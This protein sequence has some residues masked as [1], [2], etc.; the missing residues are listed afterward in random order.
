MAVPPTRSRCGTRQ[1]LSPSPRGRDS[2]PREGGPGAVMQLQDG[3]GCGTDTSLARSLTINFVC[4]Q[5][6]A[7]GIATVTF[8]NETSL[9][10]YAATI[11]TL[12]VCPPHTVSTCGT[13][14]L[15]LTSIT[16]TDLVYVDTTRNYT[17]YYRPCGVVTS[18]QC[19]NNSYADVDASMLCQAAGTAG[20]LTSNA[21]D[22]AWWNPTLAN[23][24]RRQN[25]NWW[26]LTISDGQTCDAAAGVS[27]QL[28][29]NF[30]CSASATTPV[31]T[32]VN[33]TTTCYYVATVMT[34]LACNTTGIITT[35][36]DCGGDYDLD[37]LSQQD[38]V[39]TP[40]NSGFSYALRPCC[41]VA[42]A[43]CQAHNNT[44]SSMM[45]QTQQGS[46][47]TFDLAI[48]DPT[49]VSYTPT[50]QGISMYLSDGDFCAATGV[51]RSLT[52]NINCQPGPLG[53]QAKLL[54]VVEANTCQYVATVTTNQVCRVGR[55]NGF[56]GS[57]NYDFSLAGGVDYQWTSADGQYT[58]YFQPCGSVS[59]PQCNSSTAAQGSMM[60]Q[61]V[62]GTGTAYDIA[63]YDSNLV[64][65]YK[66]ASGGMQLFVQDGTS[67]GGSGYLRALTVNF[68]CGA[69]P[70][71]NNVTETTT[72]NY[73]AFV[74]TP[75][76]CSPVGAG[77]STGVMLSY[78]SSTGA[79]SY[80]TPSTCGG[81]YN[82]APLTTQDLSYTSQGY[83]WYL[84]PCG[85]VSNSNC[86]AAA[87]AV[88]TA[89]W[90]LCQDSQSGSG[91]YDASLYTPYQASYFPIRNG[92]IMQ[93]ADGAVCG[94]L[95]SRVTRVLFMCNASATSAYIYN[96]TESPECTYNVYV[97][98]NLTCPVAATTCG[99]A[100]Y[101]LSALTRRGDLQLVNASSGYN[102]YFSPCSI[103][104][105]SACQA[106]PDTADAMMCQVAA[107]SNSTY[108]VAVYAPQLTQ[109]TALSNG[110]QMQIQDG[111]SSDGYDFER[112]LTVNFVCGQSGG[113]QFVSMYEATLCSY[114]AQ[115]N[116]GLACSALQTS[117]SS[118]TLSGGAIAGI[119][120]G[121][122]VAAACL[123]A[124]AVAAC[125]RWGRRPRERREGSGQRLGQH[126]VTSR[127]W[128]VQRSGG[129]SEQS[130]AGK[131]GPKRALVSGGNRGL[132]AAVERSC[133]LLPQCGERLGACPCRCWRS[134]LSVVCVLWFIS[135]RCR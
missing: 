37:F 91:T 90:M 95:G 30:M 27:R 24:R 32:L 79:Y 9:C 44:Q 20:E 7:A 120:I 21:Y 48:Y 86:T 53:D 94:T 124:L 97:Y 45:C 123:G 111:A 104:Q 22:L 49:V 131:H 78:P 122:L 34:A 126:C 125:L 19:A 115:I 96:I 59:N 92:V 28:T 70:A 132:S 26:Q 116:T 50:L 11:Q 103:V 47:T 75:Q 12:A 129:E 117:S 40:V 36:N 33:E 77:Q 128:V 87:A 58:Y 57:A 2:G 23:W 133:T 35:Q 1:S 98:T 3:Q 54:S 41:V 107:G 69:S 109:W 100:G 64:S 71:L 56:C 114:V 108:D 43:Q 10:A 4:N 84:R 5:Q 106:N 82:L 85:A 101:D 105:N 52:L 102:W 80:E 88:G 119:V 68:V 76:A 42:N 55:P 31:M 67:C 83:V 38:L 16:S 61:Q 14:G 72:C 65:W 8:V 73:V 60:C 29:V 6:L 127:R 118:S 13:T 51:N 89:N 18:P 81:P 130:G 135:R 113:Y 17:Y 25:G 66:L 63:F 134:V 39:Y 46:S 15:D 74:T 62:Q 121:V 112:L 93:V 99:G 110:V